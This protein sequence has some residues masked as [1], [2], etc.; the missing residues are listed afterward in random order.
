MEKIIYNTKLKKI[1]VSITL[2]ILLFNFIMP[3]MVFAADDKPEAFEGAWQDIKNVEMHK[4]VENIFEA[5]IPVKNKSSVNFA[6]YNSEGIWD[7]NNG[8]NYSLS[9]TD[10]PTW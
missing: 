8:N 2:V 7:N 10:R 5:T 6:F 9:V 4:N 3:A 1:F